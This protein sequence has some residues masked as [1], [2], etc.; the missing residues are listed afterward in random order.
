MPAD[1]MG[2]DRDHEECC[3][4]HESLFQQWGSATDVDWIAISANIFDIC[5]AT[6]QKLST[7][8]VDLE[9]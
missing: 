9:F 6:N 2:G 7:V 5:L 4:I 8:N 3:G 1:Y